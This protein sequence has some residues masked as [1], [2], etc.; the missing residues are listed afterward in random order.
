MLWKH[1]LELPQL[2]RISLYNKEGRQE[3]GRV[4]WVLLQ[5]EL[6]SFL[7]LGKFSEYFLLTSHA[8]Y[9]E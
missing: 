4:E 7:L 1:R 5:M 8:K 3:S 9:C 6:V 2:C